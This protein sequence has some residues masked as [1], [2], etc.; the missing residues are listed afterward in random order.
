MARLPKP[1][2]SRWGLE[3]DPRGGSRCRQPRYHER[4]GRSLSP[5]AEAAA[6]GG[7]AVRRSRESGGRWRRRE[8]GGGSSTRE[9]HYL[10]V[11]ARPQPRL[12]GA[13][14]GRRALPGS[15]P[16]RCAPP[17]HPE[18][19]RAAR[20]GTG[21]SPRQ[22]PG[23]G[24]ARAGSGSCLVCRFHCSGSPQQPWRGTSP[25]VILRWF[26]AVVLS[27]IFVYWGKRPWLER[28]NEAA[29]PAAPGWYR[30]AP[31]RWHRRPFLPLMAPPGRGRIATFAPNPVLNRLLQWDSRAGSDPLG[32]CLPKGCSHYSH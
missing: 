17:S 1:S 25:A 29:A 24:R 9:L 26:R 31:A 13:A 5:R 20:G 30:S 19:R 28:G 8:P 27:T 2:G 3:G 15:A 11:A 22:R 21:P 10:P 7:K 32:A 18:P 12:P 14:R 4:R 23:L 16:G 6:E